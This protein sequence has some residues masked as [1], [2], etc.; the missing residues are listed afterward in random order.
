MYCKDDDKKN[1]MMEHAKKKGKQRIATQRGKSRSK[2]VKRKKPKENMQPK[3]LARYYLEAEEKR[4]NRPTTPSLHL[5]KPQPA[6]L[7]EN[8]SEIGKK[9]LV[10]AENQHKL[11]ALVERQ[12]NTDKK[13]K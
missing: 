11:K 5:S 8:R 9:K 12:I 1:R 6:W 4:Q 7:L 10:P 13:G 2:K 3:D